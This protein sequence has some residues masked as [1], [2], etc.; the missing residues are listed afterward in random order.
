MEI[1]DGEEEH[2]MKLQ[3]TGKNCVVEEWKAKYIIL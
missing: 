2:C 3:L 1:T